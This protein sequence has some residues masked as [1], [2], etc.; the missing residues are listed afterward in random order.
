MKPTRLVA[1][2]FALAA[3]L[4][5]ACGPGYLT[6]E[7]VRKHLEAPSGVVGQD[8]IGYATDDFFR[9]Q[10]ASAAEGTASFIKTS[11]SSGGAS[12]W[13]SEVIASGNM[14][15][16]VA[17]G[18]VEDIGDLFCAASL[19]ASISTFDACSET[20]ENCE[21]ELVI[22]SCV[23][24]I[25]ENGDHRA[26]GKMRFK[27]KNE[28]QPDFQRS[29]L[30]IHFEDFEFT[31]DD[32][33]GIT[34]YFGGIIAIETTE[35]PERAEV[36]FSC[37]F[38]QQRRGSERGLFEDYILERERLTVA[39]RFITE[40]S[41]EASSGSLEILAFVDESD[42][43]RD[44]SVVISFAAQ[45]RRIDEDTRIAGATLS[46]RGS[47]GAFSCTWGAASERVDEETR[48]YESEGSCI[49]EETG[50]EFNWTSTATYQND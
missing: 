6:P 45:S 40:E 50:E 8:T 24:R 12:A 15:Q 3:L 2:L 32:E 16:A 13:A 23:L 25:G 37:D 33:A 4:T 47:N 21:A 20:P 10:R 41:A 36:I 14:E 7:E 31:D 34:T 22:D 26:R 17:F 19:V 29:E 43:S 48:T 39:M 28:E 42:D 46:V 18:A 38:D 27:I 1:P 30:S 11:E 5:S 49:D 9:A 44:E 35:E